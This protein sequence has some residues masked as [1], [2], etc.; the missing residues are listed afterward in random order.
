[1]LHNMSLL[2]RQSTVSA[3]IGFISE[4][5]D[6]MSALY[7]PSGNICMQLYTYLFYCSVKKFLKLVL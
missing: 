1:M 3:L 7:F 2:L 4:A 5:V 6:D